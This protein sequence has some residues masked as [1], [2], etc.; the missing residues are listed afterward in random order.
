VHEPNVR[1]IDGCFNGFEIV[2]ASCTS[3]QRHHIAR[4][5]SA[6]NNRHDMRFPGFKGAAFFF[7]RLLAG[8][9]QF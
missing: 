2:S 4:L 1:Y 3:P 7:V 8:I 6:F 5:L 9:G